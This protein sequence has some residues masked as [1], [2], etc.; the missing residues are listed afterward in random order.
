MEWARHL[1][2]NEVLFKSSLDSG[3]W[4]EVIARHAGHAGRW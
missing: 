4:C 3:R 2:A 1:G